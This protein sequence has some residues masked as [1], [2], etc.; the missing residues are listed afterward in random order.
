MFFR[1][2]MATCSILGFAASCANGGSSADPMVDRCAEAAAAL[3]EC[4]GEVPPDFL[5]AC[6]HDQSEETLAV[7]DQLVDSSCAEADTDAKE[8]GLLEAAFAQVCA[9]VVGAAFLVNRLRSPASVPLPQG[10]RD[11]LR[12]F[13]GNMVD[14][15]KV[16]WG[17]Q[18][19]DEWKILGF[20]V[21]FQFD[22]LAQTFH[23]EIFYDDAYTGDPFQLSVLAHEM[24][25][26]RQAEQR[27]GLPGFANEYC[28]AFWRSG[29]SYEENAL[30]KEAQMVEQQV[31]SCLMFGSGC[32]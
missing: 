11:K 9:P 3:E 2:V 17:A 16:S 14:K 30:E 29:F 18:L 25:H 24:T 6:E 21:Q 1:R 31:A 22:V 20:K 7:I 19:A 27:G 13:F 4:S 8:D 23:T 12:R 32:P 15:V 26:T 5:D 10:D 28:R